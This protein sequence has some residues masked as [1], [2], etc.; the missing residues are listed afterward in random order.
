MFPVGIRMY[1]CVTRMKYPYV[2]RMYPSGVLAI[3]LMKSLT[4]G[5]GLNSPNVRSSKTGLNSNPDSGF[6]LP[7]VP[8]VFLACGGNFRCWPKAEAARKTFAFRA[9]PYQAVRVTTHK[10]AWVKLLLYLISIVTRSSPH[11]VREMNQTQGSKNCC[12]FQKY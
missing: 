1:P 6:F 2:T 11:L 7:W 10:G 3:R 8:E 5:L 9:G 12:L 4:F